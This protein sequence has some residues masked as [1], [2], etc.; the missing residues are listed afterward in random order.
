MDIKT[1]ENEFEKTAKTEDFSAH[2]I[3]I[4]ILLTTS[5]PEILLFHFSLLVKTESANKKLYQRLRAAFCKRG[6]S[7]KAFL[8]ARTEQ[9]SDPKMT[10]DAIQILGHIRAREVLPISR[11]YLFD[12]NNYLRYN[13]IIVL[14][15]MGEAND[16]DLLGTRMKQEI[17]P[18][19]RGYLATALRQIFLRLPETKDA[20]LRYLKNAIEIEQNESTLEFM[21]IGAQTV[22]KEYFGLR[23]SINQGVVTGDIQKAKT[24]A[25]SYFETIARE[26]KG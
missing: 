11:N 1:L 18:G 26:T 25:L 2:N 4:K 12:E 5:T 3:F 21:I 20:C 16:V 22:S 14:G 7:A 24:R 13:S 6:E 19:L 15:W 17:D 9:E 8:I 10:G 23:E